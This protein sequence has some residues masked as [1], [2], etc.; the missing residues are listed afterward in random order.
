M[1]GVNGMTDAF[2]MA[3]KKPC[4][5]DCLLMGIESGLEYADGRTA[6]T[7]TGSWLHH[8]V[9]I[10]AGPKVQDIMCGAGKG[11]A[12]FM[13]GN[14][15]TPNIFFRQGI[16]IKSGYPLHKEDTFVYSI[17]L[18]NMDPKEK[19]VWLTMSFEY[20]D[21]ANHPEFRPIHQ[22]FLSIGPSCSGFVNPAGA[23][24]LTMTGQPKSK[25]F[26]E[27]SI[28]WVSRVDGDILGTGGHLHDG[29]TT[30]EVWHNDKLA[31]DSRATYGGAGFTQGEGMAGMAVG[32]DPTEHISSMKTC[33]NLGPIKKKDTI[34]L[35]AKYDFTQHKG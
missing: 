25:V 10:N 12:L 9:L 3:V 1:M 24:N 7:D 29:G 18:M 34:T 17:E 11:E 14:E 21:G 26:S 33:Q 35:N 13:D 31:C 6:N 8:V 30:L 5:G 19:Y 23:S 28:P 22:L 20:L 2:G 15:R 4:D 16:D 32:G 27:R